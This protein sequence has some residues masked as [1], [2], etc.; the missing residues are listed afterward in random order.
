MPTL[1]V[2]PST[3]GNPYAFTSPTR[4]KT[5]KASARYRVM[6]SV[7]TR[8]ALV[9]AAGP[10]P[11]PDRVARGPTVPA[12]LPVG[13]APGSVAG[14]D[15]HA[16]TVGLHAEHARVV[17]SRRA[18]SSVLPDGAE[19]RQLG[20]EETAGGLEECRS[21]V[22]RIR[23]CGKRALSSA[24]VHPVCEGVAGGSRPSG[25]RR[26][27]G[28]AAGPRIMPPTRSISVRPVIDCSSARGSMRGLL[29]GHI[30]APSGS[31]PRIGGSVRRKRPG[32]GRYQSTRCPTCSML[33]GDLVCSHDLLGVGLGRSSHTCR[34]IW[35]TR[36]G[37]RPVR[38]RGGSGSRE[39]CVAQ[40]WYALL[41]LSIEYRS[42]EEEHC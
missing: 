35:L 26:L 1:I 34:C 13:M 3:E 28:S 15:Q 23:C 39:V 42:S 41:A 6:A 40:S 16:I 38:H 20:A 24:G 27:R 29:V 36:D 30:A 22:D 25:Q 33:A 14:E 32:H 8:P 10:D 37:L 17:M 18:Q 12:P 9:A 4:S 2:A 5:G 11:V 19:Y 31:E 21:S 7:H